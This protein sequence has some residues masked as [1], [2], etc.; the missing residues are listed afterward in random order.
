M[1][2]GRSVVECGVRQPSLALKMEECRQ[3]LETGKSKKTD[4]PLEPPKGTQPFQHPELSPGCPIF[5]FQT[6]RT[7]KE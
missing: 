2:E 1:E 3:P 6:S 7:V 5:R 4:S